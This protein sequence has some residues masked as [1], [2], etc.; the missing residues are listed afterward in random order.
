MTDW[1]KTYSTWFNGALAVLGAL[2]ATIVY[3][4]SQ[5]TTL[6][7]W[8]LPAAAT[9]VGAF[10]VF[11]RSLP[12]PEKPEEKDR[13]RIVSERGWVPLYLLPLLALFAFVTL[14]LIGCAPRLTETEVRCLASVEVRESLELAACGDDTT[15][16]CSTDAVMDKY[17]P[18]AL[19]CVSGGAQ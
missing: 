6:P 14:F 8:V 4:Q 18:Q 15:G 5:D 13:I 3:L 12:Q 19:A 9:F 11:L 1:K 16:D 2:A 10:T 17:D 7:A